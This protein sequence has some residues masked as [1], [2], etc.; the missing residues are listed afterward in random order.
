MEPPTHPSGSL[1]VALA[2]P[3]GMT[4]RGRSCRLTII[5][6][7]ITAMTFT[8]KPPQ[9]HY[10]LMLNSGTL[11]LHSVSP[12]PGICPSGVYLQHGLSGMVP[13]ALKRHDIHLGLGEVF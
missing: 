2:A 8:G 4:D 7:L 10:L 11:K 5:V 3:A 6:L 12:P 13:G 9:S 1:I